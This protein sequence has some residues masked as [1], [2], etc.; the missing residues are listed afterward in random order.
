MKT[1][2]LLL[3]AVALLLA[4]ICRTESQVGGIS[5]LFLWVAGMVGG[6]FIPTFILGDVL[7]AVGKAVPHYWALQAYT[8]LTLRGLGV[9]DILPQL[10]VLAGFTVVFFGIGLWRFSFD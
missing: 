9:V 5:S 7:S 10:G 2:K 1:P 3:T 4:A 8:D 6:A